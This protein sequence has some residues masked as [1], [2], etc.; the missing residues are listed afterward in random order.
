MEKEDIDK[1]F[2]MKP[3]QLPK[4]PQHQPTFIHK[5]KG[6]FVEIEMHNGERL[7]GTIVAWNNY[8]ILFLEMETTVPIILMKNFISCIIPQDSV[9]PFAKVVD[10]NGQTKTD[11]V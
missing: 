8:E 7:P 2:T 10:Q 11:S 6:K 9:D 4:K 5:L 1:L 3:P